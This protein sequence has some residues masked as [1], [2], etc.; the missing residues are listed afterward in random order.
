MNAKY[1]L[2]SGIA[3]CMLV[4][5]VT[6]TACKKDD[7]EPQPNVEVDIPAEAAGG[8][9]PVTVTCNTAWTVAVNT[10]AAW[11]TISPAPPTSKTNASPAPYRKAFGCAVLNNNN[12][13][14]LL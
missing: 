14:Y 1:C 2:M 13:Q 12:N 5:T 7:P 4:V 3:L 6:F 8:S 10:D 11:C 9:Y